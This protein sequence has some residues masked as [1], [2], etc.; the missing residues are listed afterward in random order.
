M[1]SILESCQIIYNKDSIQDLVEMLI[2]KEAKHGEMSEVNQMTQEQ[3]WKS[4]ATGFIEL[5]IQNEKL[6]VQIKANMYRGG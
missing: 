3:N 4:L 6:S 5:W 1:N 2:P